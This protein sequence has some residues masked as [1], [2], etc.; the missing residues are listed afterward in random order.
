[1]LQGF[2]PRRCRRPPP[3]RDEL[4]RLHPWLHS[5]NRPSQPGSC[6]PSA[7]GGRHLVSLRVVLPR[8][9]PDQR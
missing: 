2:R 6:T 8:A 9:R 1:V 3:R 4:R 5:V 7:P